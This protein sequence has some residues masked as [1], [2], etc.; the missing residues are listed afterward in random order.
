V[1]AGGGAFISRLYAGPRGDHRRRPGQLIS[2]ECS[3][4]P[5][6]LRCLPALVGR[7]YSRG[8]VFIL[9]FEGKWGAA[10]GTALIAAEILRADLSCGSGCCAQ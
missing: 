8:G 5:G 1:A 10:L 7:C 6:A 2:G 4:T 9:T 3:Q